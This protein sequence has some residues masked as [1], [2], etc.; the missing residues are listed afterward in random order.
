MLRH[1]L[2]KTMWGAGNSSLLAT[3]AAG[4]SDSGDDGGPLDLGL[5]GSTELNNEKIRTISAEC[6][7]IDAASRALAAS[8]KA[9]ERALSALRKDTG[10]ARMEHSDFRRDSSEILEGERMDGEIREEYRREFAGEVD[11]HVRDGGAAVVSEDEN[12]PR[13][14]NGGRGQ[15]SRARRFSHRSFIGK[16]AAEARRKAASVDAIQ[17]E[18]RAGQRKIRACAEEERKILDEISDRRL[19]GAKVERERDVEVRMRERE[20]EVQ[21]NRGV[22]EAVQKA[23]NQS[24]MYAQRIAERVSSIVSKSCYLLGDL[25]TPPTLSCQA[26][27]QMSER[28][29]YMTEESD[30][31]KIND[32]KAREVA[33]LEAEERK[34]ESEL[35]ALSAQY[36]FLDGQH[37]AFEGERA[38]LYD[39]ATEMEKMTEES[40]RLVRDKDA[41]AKEDETVS[42]E[43][44][45]ATA[46]FDGAS[47]EAVDIA[48]EREAND[49]D[50]VDVKAPALKRKADA[51]M[52]KEEL[53]GELIEMQK[54]NDG[55]VGSGREAAAASGARCAEIS[56]EL[57]GGKAKRDERKEELGKIAGEDAARWEADT[58]QLKEYKV[59]R[60]DRQ[61]GTRFIFIRINVN[62]QIVPPFHPLPFP[63][64]FNKKFEE[65]T[66]AEVARLETLRMDRISSRTAQVGERQAKVAS[67]EGQVA[68]DLGHVNDAKAFLEKNSLKPREVFVEVALELDCDGEE[69]VL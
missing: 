1:L 48:T 40:T 15:V 4:P 2:I 59:R 11:A 58:K 32:A 16:K 12:S 41:K 8:V 69:I 7:D 62:S 31:G 18:I 43:L 29:Q 49:R 27:E 34:L 28:G 20:A 30:L 38:R 37:S 39:V 19:E 64:D 6:A 45:S 22:R 60:R 47:K 35:A 36:D 68:S 14:E 52:G 63:K 57:T 50:D 42:S 53:S 67:L 46:A 54:K 5:G 9:E 3:P 51:V 44:E 10:H 65:A 23:R 33:A 17:D 61:R 26:K 21:R 25:M 24:G 66:K 55:E 56:K 13:R